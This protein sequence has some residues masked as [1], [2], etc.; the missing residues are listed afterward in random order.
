M[1]SEDINKFIFINPSPNL[2]RLSKHVKSYGHEVKYTSIDNPFDNQSEKIYYFYNNENVHF[3]LTMLEKDDDDKRSLNFNKSFIQKFKFKSYKSDFS[4]YFPGFESGNFVDLQL[5]KKQRIKDILPIK[6]EIFNEYTELKKKYPDYKLIA[7][8]LPHSVFNE[9]STMEI[10]EIYETDL[11][12]KHCFGSEYF[13]LLSG[14][15]RIEIFCLNGCIYIVSPKGVP[16]LDIVRK[17]F[18]FMNKFT[19]DLKKSHSIV[20]NRFPWANVAKS[21]DFVIMNDYSFFNVSV[22]MPDRWYEAA[23]RYLCSGKLL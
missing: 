16:G 21:K 8:W 18:T 3:D 14:K 10:V 19:F 1:K 22:K 5:L 13:I 4:S 17:R 2:L 15:S 6:S 11:D 12:I 7:G 9:S 23:G 20:R